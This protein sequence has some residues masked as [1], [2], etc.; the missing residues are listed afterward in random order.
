MSDVLVTIKPD[1]AGGAEVR[2]YRD[3]IR[4]DKYYVHEGSDPRAGLPR[5]ARVLELGHE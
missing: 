1:N 2:I 3:S 4:V 5:G